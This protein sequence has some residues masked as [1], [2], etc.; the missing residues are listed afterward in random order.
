MVD[1]QRY[2]MWELFMEEGVFI[3]EGLFEGEGRKSA[4]I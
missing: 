2:G 3:V 1:R 4:S